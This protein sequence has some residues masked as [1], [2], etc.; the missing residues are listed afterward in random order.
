MV[1]QHGVLGFIRK[2]CNE[3]APTLDTRSLLS[4]K[5]SSSEYVVLQI[6]GSNQFCGEYGCLTGASALVS[7]SHLVE[8]SAITTFASAMLL[9]LSL[10]ALVLGWPDRSM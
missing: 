4:T 10:V 5:E 8:N 7:R 1:Q 2:L 9:I 6:L 3:P